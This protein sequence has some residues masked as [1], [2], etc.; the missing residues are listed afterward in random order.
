MFKKLLNE[1]SYQV[2]NSYVSYGPGDQHIVK[3]INSLNSKF[4]RLIAENCRD[5]VSLIEDAI[6]G[7][8]VVYTPEDLA[9]IISIFNST[10]QNLNHEFIM[11]NSWVNERP[12]G[13]VGV[14]AK[15]YLRDPLPCSRK[16]IIAEVQFHLYDIMD[17]TDQCPMEYTH[18]I[19]EITR[20]MI[21]NDPNDT[22]II[23]GDLAQKFVFLF[24]LLRNSGTIPPLNSGTR[25][26]VINVRR[27]REEGYSL[28]YDGNNG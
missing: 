20:E 28:E 25:S 5:P 6:R 4:H 22:N 17:G 12:S 27:G 16:N 9:D 18:K 2:E 26:A 8:L 13:Y 3:S 11:D 19:Y 15:V 21:I 24:G 7:S 1:T 23:K 10:A 14:H